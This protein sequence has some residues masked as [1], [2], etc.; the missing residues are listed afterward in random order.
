[1]ND[2]A[3]NY[4]KTIIYA[5]HDIEEASKLSHDV[6]ILNKGELIVFD[7]ANSFKNININKTIVKMVLP[8]NYLLPEQLKHSL[9][10]KGVFEQN[11][12]IINLYIE[13][14]NK[15]IREIMELIE[16]EPILVSLKDQSLEE[17]YIE[18]TNK[19]HI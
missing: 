10:R 13:R 8:K 14:S 7:K 9:K 17:F 2:L 5:T 19:E 4:S 12:K 15:I 16:E 6:V 1:M 3:D 11:N 18:I